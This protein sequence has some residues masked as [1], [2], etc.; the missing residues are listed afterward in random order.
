MVP[1]AIA[2]RPGIWPNRAV[3]AVFALYIVV[4]GYNL[5]YPSQMLWDEKYYIPQAQQ[6]ANG[7]GLRETSH[8]PLGKFLTALAIVIC[9]DTPTAWRVPA[10]IGG[11]GILWCVYVLGVAL[12]RSPAAALIATTLLAC[13]SLA[14][15]QSRTAI[16]SSIMLFFELL[17]MVLVV[18]CRDRGSAVLLG[19]SAI[20][21]GA[22]VSTRWV[23]FSAL[24]VIA[25]FAWS[26]FEGRSIGVRRIFAMCALFV[27]LSVSVYLVLFSVGPLSRGQGIFD[28]LKLNVRMFSLHWANLSVEHRYSSPWWSWPLM[29]RP[30]WWGFES[31]PMTAAD[32]SQVVEGMISI[33]NPVFFA[34]IPIAV[35]WGAYRAL[36]CRSVYHT[37]VLI[38]V[39]TQWLQWSWVP[40]NTFLHYFYTVLPFAALL[41]GDVLVAVWRSSVVGKVLC[42]TYITA[43]V[44]M[45]AYW[46]PLLT[47]MQ[48]SRAFVDQH[49]WIESWW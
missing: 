32:G 42:A 35:V 44:G 33:G 17:A 34:A 47:A 11:V 40:Q 2:G 20:A 31:Y 23:A 46:Y 28:A 36:W 37:I 22:A 15:V 30:V 45:F 29:M 19:L 4:A 6:L 1:I 10:L 41:I 18:K 8:P 5:G 27:L 7:L 9:G 24:P 26:S 38:A 13:E 49:M 39:F 21:F 16:Y 14:F 3:W 48:V 25:L 43:A 12:L